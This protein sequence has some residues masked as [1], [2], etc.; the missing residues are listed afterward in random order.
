MDFGQTGR[1]GPRVS[2]Q[3]KNPEFLDVSA[4]QGWQVVSQKPRPPLLQ[5][6]SLVLTFRG[7]STSGHKVLS[8][9]P[10]KKSPVTPPGID[11]GTFRLLA[12]CLN[13]YATP[14]PRCQAGTGPKTKGGVPAVLQPSKSKLKYKL[15]TR[16]Y[17]IFY[18]IGHSA[19]ISH[20]NR[21]ITVTLEFL[22]DE[23][24]ILD[25]LEKAV[26]TCVFNQVIESWN[27]QRFLIL[28]LKLNFLRMERHLCVA[29]G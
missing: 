26:R 19:V 24:K 3:V 23:I 13:H 25:Q 22:K 18:M 29:L 12:Q 9:A 16:Q 10:R 11:P 6:K 21:L 1:G 4:L 8:G 5:E 27:Q 15:Q 17:K 20:G 28:I 14:G 7:E 2:G